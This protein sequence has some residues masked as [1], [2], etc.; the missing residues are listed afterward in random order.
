MYDKSGGRGVH[1]TARFWSTIGARASVLR[2]CKTA[3]S[4]KPTK[5]KHS[6]SPKNM[7]PVGLEP[8][9]PKKADFKSAASADSATTPN[10]AKQF[11]TRSERVQYPIMVCRAQQNILRISLKQARNDVWEKSRA[12]AMKQKT[13]TRWRVGIN[14]FRGWLLHIRWEQHARYNVNHPVGGALV[15]QERRDA[16]PVHHDCAVWLDL[17]CEDVAAERFQF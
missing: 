9:L 10:L 6:G 5:H 1:T 2:L 4:A 17:Q 16:L 11:S 12:F 3:R 15:E 8:T 13:P 7:G 14:V